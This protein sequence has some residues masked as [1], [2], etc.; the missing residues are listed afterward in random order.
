VVEL[1][2]SS[3]LCLP[4]EIDS[5]TSGGGGDTWRHV[6]KRN[7]NGRSEEEKPVATIKHQKSIFIHFKYGA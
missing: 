4:V 6:T 1:M 2:L 7:E 5:R 3:R